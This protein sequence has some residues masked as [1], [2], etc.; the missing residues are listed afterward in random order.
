C[1][2]CSMDDHRVARAAFAEC[3]ADRRQDFFTTEEAVA[4]PHREARN[5]GISTVLARRST[6]SSGRQLSQAILELAEPVGDYGRALHGDL[7][8]DDRLGATRHGHIEPAVAE[9]VGQR[10]DCCRPNEG[11]FVLKGCEHGG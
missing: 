2:T 6:G 4:P 7:I 10:I 11:L 5:V 3:L 8:L 1:T 9:Y